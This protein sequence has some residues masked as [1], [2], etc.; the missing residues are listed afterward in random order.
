MSEKTLRDYVALISE[1]DIMPMNI[2]NPPIETTNDEQAA[3]QE[4]VD[5]FEKELE[6]LFIQYHASAERIGGQYRA[7]GIKSLIKASLKR[8]YAKHFSDIY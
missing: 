7:P 6:T 8:V 4:L 1:A 2:N 5:K 3:V